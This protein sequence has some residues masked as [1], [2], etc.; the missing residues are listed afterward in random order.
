MSLRHFGRASALSPFQREEAVRRT[1]VGR[2]AYTKMKEDEA[3]VVIRD[4]E[5][6]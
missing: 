1:L 2:N 5:K 6:N 4:G 3:I